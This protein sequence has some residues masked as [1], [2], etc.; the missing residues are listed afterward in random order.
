M[1][2][3]CSLFAFI[4]KITTFQTLYLANTIWSIFLEFLIFYLKLVSVDIS[5][6]YQIQT[7]IFLRYSI[8]ICQLLFK[9]CKFELKC[10]KTRLKKLRSLTT[11]YRCIKLNKLKL[12]H[13]MNNYSMY[14]STCMSQNGQMM[15]NCVGFILLKRDACRNF[16]ITY[17]WK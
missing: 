2:L 4:L 15:A 11:R 13:Y 3:W 14:V 1:V 5:L 8:T 16:Y 12:M 9:K 6:H 10:T 7:V 17:F